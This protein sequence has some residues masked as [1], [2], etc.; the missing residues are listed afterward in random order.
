MPGRDGLEVL[1]ELAAAA[2]RPAGDRRHRTGRL[3]RGDRGD[4]SR[5]LRLLEQAIR[6]RRGSADPETGLEAT[7][8]GH[9]G[10]GPASADEAGRRRNSGRIRRRARADRPECRDARGLQGDRAGGRDRCPRLDRRRERNRQGAGRRCAPSPLI[11]RRR[12]VRSVSIAERCPR[13][14]SKASCSATRHGAFTGADRQKPGRF[15]R[16]AGGTIFLDEVGELPLSAQAKILRVLQQREFERVGGTETLR[17]DARVI[18]ATH[19]DL[20]RRSPPVGSARTCSTASTSRGSS[21]RRSATAPRISAPWPSTSSDGSSGGTAGASCHSPPRRCN[22]FG[23]DPGRETSA[24]WRTPWRV[25][26]SPRG[27][28][29]SCPNI[30]MPTSRHELTAPRPEVPGRVVAATCLAGRCRTAR[31]RARPCWPAAA[32]APGPPNASA[33]AAAS[34]STR[35]ASTTL[36]PERSGRKS[37][38]QDAPSLGPGVESRMRSAIS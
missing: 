21:S 34:S 18:S 7:G 4:A 19:R 35:F 26:R 5:S 31:D 12:P 6:P 33:S 38:Y 2:G 36:V 27:A 20:F 37:V 32:I 25:R 1:A 17:T 9:R 16:A 3:G 22:R 13:A 14:W 15:E 8:P 24:N 28:G 29:R 11:A 23:S 30:S 10:Q